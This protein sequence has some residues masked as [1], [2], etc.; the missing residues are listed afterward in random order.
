[1]PKEPTTYFPDD[2]DKAISFLN[3]L[4]EEGATWRDKWSTRWEPNIQIARGDC[5]PDKDVNPLFMAN[6]ISAAL[7]RLAGLTVETKPAI[8]IGV[9]KAGLIATGDIIRA[10]VEAGWDEQSVQM[11]N[12]T[13]SGFLQA[14]GCGYAKIVWNPDADYGNGDIEISPRDPRCI[15]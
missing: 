15:K 14:V 7:D 13:L 2:P 4:D 5:W 9:R 8:N 6:L 3:R 1:M 12:E 11:M 10:V